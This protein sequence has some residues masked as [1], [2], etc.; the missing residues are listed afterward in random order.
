MGR[1]TMQSSQGEAAVLLPRIG[2]R[3]SLLRSAR[4]RAAVIRPIYGP[5]ALGV[6]VAS[7]VLVVVVASSAPGV[8]VGPSFAAFPT[9]LS[10]PLHGLFGSLL[11]RPDG[12]AV[13]STQVIDWGIS[14]VFAL[15]FAAY[16]VALASART[17]S[18]RAIAITVAAL[19]TFLVLSPPLGLTDVF[20]YLGYARLGA[21]HGLNPY[22]HVIHDESLDPVYLWV[23]WRN[24]HSPY[25]QLFTLLTYPLGLLPLGSAL[26]VLK[27][28]LVALMGVFVALV[29]KCARQLGYDGRF[30][31]LFVALNPIILIWDV[32]GFHNDPV[33][34]VPM[35]AAI[36]LVIARR[37]RWAGAALAVAV[38]VKVTIVLLLPFLMLAAY[39]HRRSLQVVVGF[40]LGAIPLAA[41][42]IAAFGLSMPNVADQSRIVTPL[43]VVNLAGVVL[44]L[45]GASPLMENGSKV[46]LVVAVGALLLM[47]VTRGRPDWLTGAGWATLGLLACTS[48]LMPWYIVWALPLVALSTSRWLR[49]TT[50]VFS[51]FAAFTFLPV[52][53]NVLYYLHLQLMKSTPDRIATYYLRSVQH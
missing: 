39:R 42:S 4:A 3:G 38:A 8:L 12:K 24:Y 36:S 5:V 45:G 52:T 31:V 47:S 43:S 51:V 20:N 53:T 11:Q 7:T 18:M 17:L 46:L 29:W 10:G 37:Y 44:H 33:V 40:V 21:L 25:G 35:M 16:G 2:A 1:M 34:L 32:G 6:L 27:V 30:A 49:R 23:S 48:W 50:L 14:G 41:V 26:W 22:T 9:W 15:M 28:G 13:I 19:Y